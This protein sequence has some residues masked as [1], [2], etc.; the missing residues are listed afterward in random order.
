[1]EKSNTNRGAGISV[2]LSL[3]LVVI[4]ALLGTMVEVGRGKVCQ[5]HGRRTLRSAADSLLTEYN[6]PLFQEYHLFS[7][8][9]WEN[10]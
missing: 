2:F 9:M 4:L 5:V 6:L 7:W 8:K 10:P 1:M 3:T